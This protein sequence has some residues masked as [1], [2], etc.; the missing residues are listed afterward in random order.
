MRRAAAPAVKS[1]APARRRPTA[2]PVRLFRQMS[3]RRVSTADRK[4]VLPFQTWYS[5][6]VLGTL[7]LLDVQW[8]VSLNCFTQIDTAFAREVPPYDERVQL[9]PHV[10]RSI[11]ERAN[12]TGFATLKRAALAMS[13]AYRDGRTPRLSAEERTAAY[14]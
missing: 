7:L 11:E 5:L 4:R 2:A 3:S 1:W 10:R 8:G 9:P 6:L 14:L 12:A 13:D